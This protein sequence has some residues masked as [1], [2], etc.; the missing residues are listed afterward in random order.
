MEA[1]AAAGKTVDKK[2]ELVFEKPTSITPLWK[3]NR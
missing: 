2:V 3:S 1:A